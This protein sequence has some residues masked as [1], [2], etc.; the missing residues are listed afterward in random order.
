MKTIL[1]SS[2]Y[3]IIMVI[4]CLLSIDFISMNMG[5]TQVGQAEQYVEDYIELNGECQDGNVLDAATVEAIN[6]ELG[7]SGMTFTYEYMDSTESHAYY[8]VQV[9]YSLRSAFFNLGKTHTFDGIAR[10]DI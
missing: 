4:I 9:H 6:K 5:I 3:L 1:E 8:K 2:I 7:K 10:V